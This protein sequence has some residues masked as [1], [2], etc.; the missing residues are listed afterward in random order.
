MPFPVTKKPVGVRPT[1]NLSGGRQRTG[2]L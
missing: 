1:N 2:R